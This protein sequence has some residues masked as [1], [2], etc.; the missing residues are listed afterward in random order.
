MT[1]Q[2]VRF[3]AFLRQSKKDVFRQSLV[4]MPKCGEILEATCRRDKR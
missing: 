4:I 3:Q 1:D 2:L